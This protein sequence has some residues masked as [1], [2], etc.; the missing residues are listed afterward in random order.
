MKPVLYISNSARGEY[1]GRLQWAERLAKLGWN[2]TFVLPKHDLEYIRKI[3][4]R[5]VPVLGWNLN[6]SGRSLGNRARAIY[7]LYRIIIRRNC[8]VIHSFGHEANICSAAAAWFAGKHCVINHV[9]GIGS[10]LLSPGSLAARG[11]KFLYRLFQGSVTAYVFQNEDDRQEFSATFRKT[12]VVIKG[13][14][15]DIEKWCP[16]TPGE[17]DIAHTRAS[18]GLLP[19]SVVITYVGRIVKDKGIGELV[20]A[21]EIVRQQCPEAELLVVGE[22]DPGNPSRLTAREMALLRRPGVRLAGRRDDIAAI[23]LAT[24]VFA[25]PSYREGIPR[26]TLEAMAMKKPVVTT[27][28]PGCR[29]T[30]EQGINGIVVPVGDVKELAAA[31]TR[32]VRDS[33]LREQMGGAGRRKVCAEFAIAD[34]VRK[35]AETYES[36]G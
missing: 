13:T 4:E 15:V 31:L 34:I 6:P 20:E 3:E 27:D 9:T 28:S 18:L 7:Q 35:V 8:E 25:N 24:D 1:T 22:P 12:P 11:M 14:G 23:L 19:G 2:V 26:S 16:R 29:E 32:L 5:H 10:V 17:D 30:V 36:L 33:G 21:F